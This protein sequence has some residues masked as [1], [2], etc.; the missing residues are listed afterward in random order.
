MRQVSANRGERINDSCTSVPLLSSALLSN[1]FDLGSRA[2]GDLLRRSSKAPTATQ[3]Q[4]VPSFTTSLLS[5]SEKSEE[6]RID[7]PP[8]CQLSL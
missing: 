8:G 3:S 4:V 7:I 1:A 6:V 2:L 5:F